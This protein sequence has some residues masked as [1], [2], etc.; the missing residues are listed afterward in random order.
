MAIAALDN[1]RSK[2][3]AYADRTDEELAGA[4]A[5]K[6]PQE[7]GM[8]P[9]MVARESTISGYNPSTRAT[10]TAAENR[11]NQ[12]D[13]LKQLIGGSNAGNTWQKDKSFGEN[14]GNWASYPIKTALAT[15]GSYGQAAEGALSSPIIAAQ[16]SDTRPLETIK[17]SITGEAPTE[18]GDIGV[19][20]GMPKPLAA[21]LGLAGTALIPGIG[22]LST[23]AG[24]AARLG[25]EALSSTAG[26]AG[27]GAAR[28]HLDLLARA[29]PEAAQH[30]I[31]KQFSMIKPWQKV[32]DID[33]EITAAVA[34]G[35]RSADSMQRRAS[36]VFGYGMNKA[37]GD[38]IDVA[39]NGLIGRAE[40][41][42][43]NTLG[44]NWVEKTDDAGN[45]I[46]RKL[47]GNARIPGS[48]ALAAIIQ[49]LGTTARPTVSKL[50][51]SLSELDGLIE[52]QGDAMGTKAVR[53]QAAK[54]ASGIRAAI[55]EQSPIMKAFNERYG[56]MVA[57]LNPDDAS[58]LP[59]IFDLLEAKSQGGTKL[60][61]YFA[62]P[63]E[64]KQV[65]ARF[66]AQL[67]EGRKFL[68]Q[69]KDA[70]TN[71]AFKE[72]KP[73]A[74]FSLM[75][76]V[77]ATYLAATNPAYLPMLG[78]GVGASSAR[79]SI[80]GHRLLN[81]LV[82]GS[83]EAKS[84]MLSTPLGQAFS[85]LTERGVIGAGIVRGLT[86]PEDQQQE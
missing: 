1:F 34:K 60:S 61:N 58:K 28:V 2:Y 66:D 42:G 54:L 62:L 35:Q 33:S 57:N 67:P 19:N 12:I 8:L 71:A 75:G 7:Y 56:K 40:T 77:A 5:T 14:V 36:Q 84:K 22:E 76:P 24:K 3:P 86:R 55:N 74:G 16:R 31:S 73:K 78:A 11:T 70:S 38:V 37:K 49:D 9:S 17:R 80:L 65:L 68:E 4:L 63:Q 21:G 59:G 32:A 23:K 18:F 79:G 48:N 10:A 20:A 81:K 82:S 39:S 26:K 46:S 15:L 27:V 45:V 6:Y 25:G 50:R 13:R 53:A 29:N 47:K 72:W 64:A 30:A 44:L 69:L 85:T 51:V 41:E 83:T 43:V 52:K